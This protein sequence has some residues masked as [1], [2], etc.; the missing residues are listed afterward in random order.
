MS[1][2]KR[3]ILMHEWQNAWDNYRYFFGMRFELLKYVFSVV[4]AVL[5]ATPV[6]LSYVQ[7]RG[8]A[9]REDYW[10][11]LFLIVTV[12]LLAFL[13]LLAYGMLVNWNVALGKH[14]KVATNIREYLFGENAPELQLT[15]VHVPGDPTGDRWIGKLHSSP[16][17]TEYTA[18]VLLLVLLLIDFILAVWLAC[19]NSHPVVARCAPL[20][21]PACL[22]VAWVFAHC[23]RQCIADQDKGTEG[24]QPRA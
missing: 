7:S 13:A 19:H 14:E 1:D 16:Q 5:G 9:I 22:T 18:N 2:D 12:G 15:T 3:K 11:L 6:V 23:R 4:F 17:A 10:V 8:I 20:L 21:L 24:S